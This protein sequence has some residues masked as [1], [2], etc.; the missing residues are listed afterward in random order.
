M[1]CSITLPAQNA[2][3]DS[4][5]TLIK[6]A[7]EDTNK[8]N[9]LN[10]ICWEYR[11]IGDYDKGLQY[12]TIGLNL[13]KKLHF[14][15]GTASSYNNIGIIYANQGNYDKAL[16][17]HF[18]SLKLKETLG[19]KQGI[20]YSYN[21]IGGIYLNQGNYDKALE[22]YFASLKLLE[23]IGDKRGV[24]SSY[25]NI[26]GIYWNQGN[27]DKA[28][29][30]HFASLKLWEALG[31]KKGIADSYNNIG[32]I[33]ESQGN[34]DKALEN[35]F[36][37]LKIKE[38]IGY[39]RG[40][41]TSYNNIGV[42]Y[43]DQ[44][45]YDKALENYFASLK[46][47]VAIG[48]KQGVAMTYNNIGDIYLKQGK[49]TEANEQALLS[50]SIAKEIGAKE[51]IKAAYQTLSLTD[52][53]TSN[54]KGAY[55]HHKLYKEINDSIFNDESFEKT[56][57]MT[58]MYESE[59]KEAQIQLLEKEKE[60]QT[61]VAT[62]DKKRLLAEADKNQK[63]AA[64]DKKTAL[65][66]ADKKTAQA[67]KK[68]ILAET[69]K[70]NTLLEAE[71]NMAISEVEKKKQRTIIYA[72]IG[73]LLLLIV[74]SVFMF[75]RWR[76][77]QKQKLIIEEKEKETH[78]QKEI[79]EEKHKEITDSINYA[80][81]IQR[82][83]LATSE[84]LDQHLKDYFVFFRP[85]DVV[86]GDFY[87]AGELNNGNFAFSVA[88]STGHGVPGAIMSILNISSLEKSIEKETAPDQILN[89]T[90]KIIIDRLRNDGSPEGGK[91]G[92]D[93]SLLVINQD[94]TQ[95]SFA[96]AN[97]PVFIIRLVR[98]SVLDTE[99]DNEVTAQA[100][101]DG[102]ELIEF[103]PDKMPVGKHDNDK[104]SFTLHTALLQK[105]DVIYALTDGFPDQFGG[106]KGKK[107]M[108]KNLKELLSQIAHLPMLEQEQKLADEFDKWKGSNEQVDDVCIIGVRI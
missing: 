32:I 53:A 29:E 87:W 14:K 86:S 16:E 101:N 43:A 91:D 70:K 35:H 42:I 64:A 95:L 62:A 4:L 99:S 18:A 96:S 84:M 27:Y 5:L 103:K 104:D 47:K 54:F 41:A 48:D 107:Y 34:Y 12:G 31:D 39:K 69:D 36:F 100:R 17:N 65:A 9:H 51:D 37:S 3:I 22:N 25:N 73:G 52:S 72:V 89:K 106:D 71:K 85:K 67:D 60:K 8:V 30:N 81:R 28:L 94:R 105:E 90:R 46:I 98:H 66:E 10:N 56:A 1:L 58:A 20:A 44:G 21:N 82:S 23:A 59:K 45:N 33:Y 11:K 92:M 83:F 61:A 79:I 24:A 93:C 19:D 97:N 108:I 55:E 13:G 68:R 78:K 2:K 76:I 77:T 26:G 88:D 49:I 7:K 15:K 50:L 80:E 102:Y 57:K 74:F 38:A 75:N 63:V 6:T 40:I